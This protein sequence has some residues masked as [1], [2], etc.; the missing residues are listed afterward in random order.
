MNGKPFKVV[1]YATDVSA[2]VNVVKLVEST[3]SKLEGGN[4]SVTISEEVP[5]EFEPLKSSINNTVAKLNQVI[6]SISNSSKALQTSLLEVVSG[7][8]DLSSRTEQQAAS[9]E[10]TAASMEEMTSTVKSN[11]GNAKSASEF[12][13]TTESKAVQG[14][15]VVNQAVHSMEQIT[16]SSN[17]VLDIIAVI[18]EIAFQTNLLAL[19][20]AVEAARA[21]DLGRGFAVV[22]GEVRTLAQRSASAAKE[23]KNLI[24]DSVSKISLGSELVNTSGKTLVEIVNSVKNVSNMI[25]TISTASG[26]QSIG[27]SQVN[28]AIAQMDEMTQQNAALVEEVNAV[29][30][31]MS[32]HAKDMLRQ[33]S[34]FNTMAR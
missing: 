2:R 27:I 12:A 22:A 33:I 21:G 11:A 6:V 29:G 13:A 32:D 10:E 14:G 15:Q 23:I 9:L 1:K 18:D 5:P 31:N 16:D 17:K 3:L 25:G 34:F 7:V 8:S 30:T 26:E 28:T 4:L 19:N 20:A 24:N